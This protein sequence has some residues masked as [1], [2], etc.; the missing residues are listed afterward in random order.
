[1]VPE[2]TRTAPAQPTAPVAGP[3]DQSW[4]RADEAL[5]GVERVEMQRL[6]SALGYGA[7]PADG[8]IGPQTRSAIRDFQAATRR[9]A[10]G[11]VS[12]EL[13]ASLR[14]EGRR[15]GVRIAAV[16]PSQQSPAQRTSQ[17]TPQRSTL[18]AADPAPTSQRTRLAGGPP[19]NPPAV[20]AP[21]LVAEPAPAQAAPIAADSSPVPAP[22]PVQTQ[23]AEQQPNPT[24]SPPPA[25]TDRPAET[26]EPTFVRR[27][28]P[29]ESDNDAGGWN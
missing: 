6:L 20:D 12:S 3:V 29:T 21:Q 13:L 25:A 23:A 4:P 18:R 26:P 14:A 1:C 7:G 17:P 8:A 16:T 28:L 27:R 19:D 10:D 24:P 2:P 9:R 11:V 5:L 15:A 22:Q